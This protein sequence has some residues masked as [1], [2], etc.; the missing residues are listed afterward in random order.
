LVFVAFLVPLGVYLVVIGL[1]NRRGRPYMVNGAWETVG[2]LAGLSGF[3]AVAGPAILSSLHERWRLWWLLADPGSPR[4]IA[5][6]SDDLGGV[7]WYN[8]T[9][10]AD[11]RAPL[12]YYLPWWT[13]ASVA[14]FVVVVL[15]AAWMIARSR[16]LTGIHG[17]DGDVAV[18]CL[19]AALRESNI[20]ATRSGN[21][22][23]FDSTTLEVDS[24]PALSHVSLRWTPGDTPLRPVIEAALAHE[25]QDAPA[26]EHDAGLWLCCAGLFVLGVGVL[27]VGTMALFSM[28]ST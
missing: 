10:H 12:G 13:S 11:P 22:F 3:L 9:P 28:R 27:I 15:A 17:I 16:R 5:G 1:L 24:F 4:G 7:Q 2:L 18:Y 6:A 25:M 20:S 26:P 23:T 8:D 21:K 14:Y 19:E